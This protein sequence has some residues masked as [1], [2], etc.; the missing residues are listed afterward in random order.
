MVAIFLGNT[1]W[2]SEVISLMGSN[3]IISVDSIIIRYQS[4]LILPTIS[5]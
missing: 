3:L 2:P 1:Y 4:N 5:I